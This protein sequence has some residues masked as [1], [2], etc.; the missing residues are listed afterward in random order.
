FTHLALIG[1]AIHFELYGKGGPAAVAGTHADRARR[2]VG[3]TFG[4]RA[5]WQACLASRRVGRLW[6]SR[7]SIYSAELARWTRPADAGVTERD[8][9]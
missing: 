2:A 3:A 8:R 9:D 7:R 4:W 1:N 6:S 5:L